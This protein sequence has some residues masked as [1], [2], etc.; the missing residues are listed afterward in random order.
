MQW[1]PALQFYLLNY[2]TEAIRALKEAGSFIAKSAN[3]LRFKSMPL[4]DNLLMN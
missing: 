2:L 4:T 1:Q 3:T